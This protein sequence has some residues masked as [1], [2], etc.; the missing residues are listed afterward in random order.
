MYI[1]V[2][3]LVK[4]WRI[5]PSSVMHVGAHLAEEYTEYNRFKWIG[6]ENKKAIWVEAQT[7]LVE[8]LN[9][10]LDLSENIVFN[11]AVWEEDEKE[12]SLNISNNGQSS[13]IFELSKHK[14]TYPDVKFIDKINVQTIRLDT[15]LES[16]NLKPDFLNLDI[17]GAEL[18][19]LKSLGERIA[20]FKWIYTEVNYE[21]LYENCAL[22]SEIDDYLKRN[23]FKRVFTVRRAGAGWGDALYIRNDQR[24][25]SNWVN[26]GLIT[27]RIRNTYSFSME[28]MRI[29]LYPLFKKYISGSS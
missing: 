10:T 2:E 8:I 4:F 9:N 23:S 13:S 14:E 16:N 15:L 3:I 27:L 25:I 28:T 17:Q 22:I 20:D 19:A 6:P 18:I 26:P 29:K 11:Y 21:S 12:I 5:S 24:K 7:S 1:P